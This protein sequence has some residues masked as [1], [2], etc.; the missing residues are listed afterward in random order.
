LEQ[1]TKTIKDYVIEFCC[2]ALVAGSIVKV[3][4]EAVCVCVCVCVCSVLQIK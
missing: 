1:K 2:C 4:A 3:Y